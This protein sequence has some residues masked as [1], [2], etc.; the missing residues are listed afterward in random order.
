MVLAP[1]PG[2]V[3]VSVTVSP[4]VIGSGPRLVTLTVQVM[5]SP[6]ATVEGEADLVTA[7]S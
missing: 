7:R 4:W 1:A 2:R 3:S 5:V 6:G